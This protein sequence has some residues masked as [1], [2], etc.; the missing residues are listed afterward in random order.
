MMRYQQPKCL[1][2]KNSQTTNAGGGV[3]RREP[4]Y[5]AGGNADWY[6]HYGEHNGGSFK[7]RAV[8]WPPYNPTRGHI[9]R[10]KHNL[11]PNVH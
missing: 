8:I 6:G 2:S 3:E 1:S 7:N 11:H 10:E 4:F 9:F 5:T